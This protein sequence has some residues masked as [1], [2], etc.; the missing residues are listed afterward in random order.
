MF[1]PQVCNYGDMFIIYWDI[2]FSGGGGVLMVRNRV[3]VPC[4]LIAT[5]HP[6]LIFSFSASFLVFPL[7]IEQCDFPENVINL[8]WP[9]RLPL[10]NTVTNVAP[11]PPLPLFSLPPA[12][13]PLRSSPKPVR[14]AWSISITYSGIF[15][16]P[17]F[18]SPPPPFIMAIFYKISSVLPS[19][20]SGGGTL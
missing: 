20:L 19:I 14:F 6:L 2:Y 16:T 7:Q 3:G 8:L 10:P 5:P 15:W 18:L 4:V 17:F 9:A 1:A 13:W 11:P 12:S